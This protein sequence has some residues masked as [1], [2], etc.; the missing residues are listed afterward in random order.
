[1]SIATLA[2]IA[3]FLSIGV[4]QFIPRDWI[5]VIV[6]VSAILLGVLVIMGL[7]PVDF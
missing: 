1:M 7:S 5:K 3:F 6:G 4:Y 2:S